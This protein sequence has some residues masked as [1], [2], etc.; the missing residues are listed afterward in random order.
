MKSVRWRVKDEERWTEGE[1][2]NGDRE[3]MHEHK[4]RKRKLTSIKN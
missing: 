1:N 3:K 2:T 4:G